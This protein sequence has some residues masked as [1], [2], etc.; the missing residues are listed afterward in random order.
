MSCPMPTDVVSCA[1]LEQ[2]VGRPSG[3]RGSTYTRIHE[4]MAVAEKT[5]TA[6]NLAKVFQLCLAW[7]QSKHKNAKTDEERK[8]KRDQQLNLNRFMGR[9][10]LE[11]SKV[12]GHM[13]DEA[14]QQLLYGL[15]NDDTSH[16]K[17]KRAVFEMFD[18][19]QSSP[20]PLLANTGRLLKGFVPCFKDIALCSG[21]VDGSLS[22]GG[23]LSINPVLSL[24]P[25]ELQGVLVHEVHH[26][27]CRHNGRSCAWGVD[28]DLAGPALYIDEFVAH[29]KQLRVT[30]PPMS[31]DALIANVNVL[32]K[33]NYPAAVDDWTDAGFRLVEHVNDLGEFAVPDNAQA[34]RSVY[35]YCWGPKRERSNAV[36]AR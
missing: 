28:K 10:Q 3:H 2:N 7:S 32:L 8:M 23:V 31:D 12:S 13:N 19:M 18:E 29:M 25:S 1:W 14:Y 27:L 34:V 6:D 24:H 11:W 33:A 16:M 20:I 26:H 4:A 35:H 30:R 17:E 22:G 9:L 21:K 36:G 15:D 5:R